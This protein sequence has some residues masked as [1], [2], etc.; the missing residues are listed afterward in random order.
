M[1]ESENIACVSRSPHALAIDAGVNDV[2]CVFVLN[3]EAPGKLLANR[4]AFARS[5]WVRSSMCSGSTL[6]QAEYTSGAARGLSAAI[7]RGIVSAWAP[8]DDAVDR[9]SR[10]GFAG[11]TETR[12]EIAGTSAVSRS[13]LDAAWLGVAR[14]GTSP[15][16]NVNSPSAT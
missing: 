5:A 7:S 10:I 13:R 9:A 8:N 11:C 4:P 1:T 6:P 16:L 2:T 15:S 3:V 14:I 12:R